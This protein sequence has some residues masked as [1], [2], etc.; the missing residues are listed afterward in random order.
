MFPMFR[1]RTKRNNGEGRIPPAPCESSS[2]QSQAAVHDSSRS[3]SAFVTTPSRRWRASGRCMRPKPRGRHSS[4][5]V[6]DC[7]RSKRPAQRSRFECFA[8]GR[9][10]RGLARIRKGI[11]IGEATR[12]RPRPAAQR[13]RREGLQVVKRV[14]DQGHVFLTSPEA[15]MTSGGRSSRGHLHPCALSAWWTPPGSSIPNS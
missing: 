2:R 1:L 8:C 3:D 7:T 10:G 13:G 14:F 12:G 15:M 6:L 9:S 4:R 5:N 11:A